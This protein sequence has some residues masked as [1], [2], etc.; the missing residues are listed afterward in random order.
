MNRRISSVKTP[1]LPAPRREL[2]EDTRQ[3]C[4]GYFKLIQAV[5]YKNIVDKAITTQLPPKGMAKN[6]KKLTGFIKPSS[7]TDYVRTAVE[8]NTKQWMQNNLLIL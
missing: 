6:V 2:D 8:N 5:H 1:L 7:P 4:K 3:L